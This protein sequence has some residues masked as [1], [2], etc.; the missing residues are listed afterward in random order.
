MYKR[1]STPAKP[2]SYKVGITK[3][4]GIQTQWQHYDQLVLEGK[5]MNDKEFEMF[6]KGMEIAII[7]SMFMFFS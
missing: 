6:I 7:I 2:H 3:S 4:V 1:T 5:T